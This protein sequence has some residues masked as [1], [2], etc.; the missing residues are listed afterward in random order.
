ME[1]A[2][3]AYRRALSL[4][5]A[6]DGSAA[7]K[8]LKSA[9][10][11]HLA[12]SYLLA[13]TVGG[14]LAEALEA[15]MAATEVA[16][17]EAKAWLIRGL[18]HERLADLDAAVRCYDRGAR[19]QPSV[20]G[21]WYNLALLLGKVGRWQGSLDAAEG[22]LAASPGH[23]AGWVARGN[24]Q[25]GLS[26]QVQ[27]DESSRKTGQP[28]RWLLADALESYRAAAR[29]APRHVAAWHNQGVVLH[30]L[31]REQESTAALS[32][33]RALEKRQP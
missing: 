22:G 23:A 25:R 31:R 32:R 28:E 20:V 3:H 15:A 2:Q 14:R 12:H 8:G 4:P 16:P 9:L 24:A 21:N 5:D 6:E 27:D 7:G 17:T 11:Y 26:K 30:E 19:E 29:A 33:A 1:E 10:L 18:V 13:D